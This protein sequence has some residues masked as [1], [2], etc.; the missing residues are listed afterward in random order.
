MADDPE[1]LDLMM[2]SGCL[3]NVVG[4]ESLDRRALRSM[5]KSPNLVRFDQYR[6]QLATLRSR[7]MQLWASFTLGH[8][9]DTEQSVADTLEFALDNK[10]CFAAF[11]ILMPYPG[12]PLYQDSPR[13][14]GCCTTAGGGC[15]RTT[16]STTRASRRADDSR[17][18]DRR[19][20]A[21]ALHL[22][23]PAVDRAPRL[24]LPHQHELTAPARP[25]PAVQPAVPREVFK[26]HGMRSATREDAMSRFF[27]VYQFAG[28]PSPCRR[29]TGAGG[30]RTTAAT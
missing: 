14:D 1:L 20:P 30:R 7:G 28:R 21:G 24:R 12:T 9:F 10:F 3:G 18:T 16:A 5:R 8:D 4:F 22:Q 19:L 25:V 29:A 11:N 17:T 26:K 23:Q 6:R 27:H 13:R 2:A 15:I